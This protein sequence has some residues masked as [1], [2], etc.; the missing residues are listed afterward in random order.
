MVVDVLDVGVI[1]LHSPLI[2]V[3]AVCAPQ[4]YLC[5]W[6]YSCAWFC[7]VVYVLLC[8]C[9]LG[10]CLQM[11]KESS[12]TNQCHLALKLHLIWAS[13]AA[14]LT[15]YNHRAQNWSNKA[16]TKAPHASSAKHA[17]KNSTFAAESRA[18]CCSVS[19]VVSVVRC[20]K[21]ERQS[22]AR[23]RL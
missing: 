5:E 21:L 17:F 16:R 6:S 20:L 8:V 15:T 12:F 1:G 7:V 22:A 18:S 10:K 2:G 4:H 19:R 11:G 23:F 14:H 13:A 9:E 3:S